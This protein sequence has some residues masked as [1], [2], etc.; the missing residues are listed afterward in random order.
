MMRA[1]QLSGQRSWQ[2]AVQIP[3][4]CCRAS[5]AILKGDAAAAGHHDMLSM[6][7]HMLI[8][9]QLIPCTG[10]VSGC[11]VCRMHGMRHSD[12]CPGEVSAAALQAVRQPS[13]DLLLAT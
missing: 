12:R 13:R 5:C 9:Q 8:V 10:C 2:H 1:M 3:L 6:L 7:T 11:R 4:T